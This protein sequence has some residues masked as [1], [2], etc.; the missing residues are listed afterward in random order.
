MKYRNLTISQAIQRGYG[1][2]LSEALGHSIYID[3]GAGVYGP[4][5]PDSYENALFLHEL[6]HKL[7]GLY[8]PQI[9]DA[10][11]LAHGD[12]GNITDYLET[13]CFK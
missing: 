8:D 7:R 1:A 11:G 4:D 5:A 13:K 6:I 10:L 3:E 2:A 9:Q 12:S